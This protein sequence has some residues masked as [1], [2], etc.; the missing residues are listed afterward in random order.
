MT[1]DCATLD[2]VSERMPPSI[3]APAI[4]AASTG[5][6][7]AAERPVIIAAAYAPMRNSAAMISSIGT[8]STTAE[9][10]RSARLSNR[11]P[12]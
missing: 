5:M 10:T 9:N 4:V 11:R 7:T 8:D 6:T 1:I 2:Q 3:S 12:R